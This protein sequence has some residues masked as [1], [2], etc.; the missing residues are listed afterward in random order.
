MF[1]VVEVDNGLQIGDVVAWNGVKFAIATNLNSPLGVLIEPASLN[2]D[3]NKNYAPV[4]FAG[5]AWAR[6]SRDIPNQ[7]GEFTVENGRIYV[8]D[9]NDIT[10]GGGI[11][12]PLPRGQSSRVAGDLVMIHI[13]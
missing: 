9:S 12:S 3:D 6:S 2:A 4:R 5:V 13:R 1:C 8:N 10:G 7:G 11:V